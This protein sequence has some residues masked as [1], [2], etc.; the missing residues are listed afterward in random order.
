MTL[1]L[2]KHTSPDLYSRSWSPILYCESNTRIRQEEEEDKSSHMLLTLTSRNLWNAGLAS[3]AILTA[4]LAFRK[5]SMYAEY[6]LARVSLENWRIEKVQ[7]WANH[8]LSVIAEQIFYLS[9]NLSM[10]NST[11]SCLKKIY[12]WLS[13]FWLIYYYCEAPWP[14]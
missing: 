14:S 5:L 7:V 1:K 9:I 8:T 12:L 11:Y 4:S 6:I 2:T 10:T 13:C 3:L